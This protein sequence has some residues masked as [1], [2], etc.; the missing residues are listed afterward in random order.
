[1]KR[2]TADRWISPYSWNSRRKTRDDASALLAIQ[3]YLS[4]RRVSPSVVR[5]SGWFV[6]FKRGYTYIRY[7]T[8]PDSTWVLY[9][10]CWYSWRS[11][12]RLHWNNLSLRGSHVFIWRSH[13]RLSTSGLSPDRIHLQRF[14]SPKCESVVVDINWFHLCIDR[15][16]VGY[17][18]LIVHH[19]S[20]VSYTR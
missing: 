2:T 8:R 12:R 7:A 10:I 20:H 14:P 18:T 3:G 1:M 11:I 4:I 13:L 19:R 16:P 5:E 15:L 6:W 17:P 9:F